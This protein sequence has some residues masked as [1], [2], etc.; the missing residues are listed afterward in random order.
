MR[1]RFKAP[2]D[3]RLIAMTSILATILAGLAFV[4]SG[5]WVAIMLWAIIFGCSA[6]GVY[7]Y[8]IQDGKIK[9]LRL[10]WSKEIRLTE[11]QNIENKP[12]AMMGS[13][14]LFGIGGL[15]GY[16]G[17]FRNGILGHYT[18]YATHGEKTVEIESNGTKFVVSPDDPNEFVESVKS[19]M[20][21]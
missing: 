17:K 3:I 9:V 16:I 4:S 21:Q 20:D 11:I 8:S 2:W 10:G 6:F 15:F 1:H 7:G 18:A 5:H 13:V 12:N 14:R 19:M